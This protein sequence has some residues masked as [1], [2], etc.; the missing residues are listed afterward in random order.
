MSLSDDIKTALAANSTLVTAFTGGI[1]TWDDLG[2]YGLNKNSYPA[3]FD[4]NQKLKPTLVI[5]ERV[6]L[7]TPFIRDQG[8]QITSVVQAVEV[9]FFADRDAGYA[10]LE[11]GQAVVKGILHDRNIGTMR[12][13][14]R[15]HRRMERDRELGMACVLYS[16]YDG[17]GEL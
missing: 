1:V 14:L 17:F 2:A 12:C 13:Q 10:T 16:V 6:L 7:A 4:A 8:T 15:E 9:W 3:A 11:S 5:R